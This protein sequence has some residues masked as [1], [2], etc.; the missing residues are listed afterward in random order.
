MQTLTFSNHDKDTFTNIIGGTEVQ[1]G[2]NRFTSLVSK[3]W[4]CLELAETSKL[5]SDM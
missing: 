1:K 2:E 4:S 3:I 5:G